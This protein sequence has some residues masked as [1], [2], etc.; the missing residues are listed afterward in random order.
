MRLQV[1]APQIVRDFLRPVLPGV[2]IG[3]QLPAGWSADSPDCLVVFSG[4]NDVTTRAWTQEAVHV[5]AYG[6][7]APS[8]RQ[9]ITYVDGLLIDRRYLRGVAVYPGTMI[10]P[11]YDDDLNC[12]V[13]SVEVSVASE[14]KEL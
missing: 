7:F 2:Y 6:A 3:A 4:N 8:V 11:V 1:D 9:L 10:A 14:R 5:T 12:F 13:A